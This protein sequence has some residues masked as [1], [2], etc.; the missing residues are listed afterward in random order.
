MKTATT[1]EADASEVARVFSELA[2]RW[3]RETAAHSVLQKKVLHPAYQRIIGLGPAVV[4]Y[5]LREL[6]RQPAHWFW[7]LN[8]ITGVDPA[9]VGSTFEEAA[10]AWLKWGKERGYL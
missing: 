3:H 10:Q 9:P 4:P 8:A 5:I 6:R 2:E 7:A 1:V